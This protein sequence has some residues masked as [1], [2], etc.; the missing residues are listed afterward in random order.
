M[1]TDMNK[2]YKAIKCI[3]RH[4]SMWCCV[5][6]ARFLCYARAVI[7]QSVYRW[8]TGWTIEVLGFD[9]RRGQGISL[10]TTASSTALVPTKP[11]IQCLPGD[12]YPRVK[13]PGRKADHS[14]SSSAEVKECVKLFLHYPNTSSWSDAQ[15]NKI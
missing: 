1:I 4:N 3:C 12:L 8:A 9:S 11:P 6:K 5:Y 15:L 13:W 7:A 14:P 10:F 2:L